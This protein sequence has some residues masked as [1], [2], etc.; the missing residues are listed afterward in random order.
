MI[1]PKSYIV[2][3]FVILIGVIIIL[4]RGCNATPAMSSKAID[5]LK[6]VIAT[7]S[8]QY[9]ARYVSYES[10]INKILVDLDTTK[11]ALAESRKQ[12]TTQGK[13]ILTTNKRLREAF[14]N[15]D[16]ATVYNSCDSLSRAID[17]I[18]QMKWNVDR[19]LDRQ[20]VLN[21]QLHTA[22]SS[23]L[24]DCREQI[25]KTR[26][27]YSALAQ[28]YEVQHQQDM[29]IIKKAKRKNKLWGIGGGILGAAFRSIFK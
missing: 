5:S 18:A 24:I 12:F 15:R 11:S 22:D 28:N 27:A 10:F 1:I 2:L 14:N 6:W 4:F 16:T 20:I 3:F 13:Q 23:A 26:S 17:S 8:T 19:E 21:E 29:D 7:D 25:T 9:A